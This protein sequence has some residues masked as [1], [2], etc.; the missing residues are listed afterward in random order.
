MIM[1]KEYE[2]LDTT[3][4]YPIQYFIGIFILI[5]LFIDE[6]IDTNDILDGWTIMAVFGKFDG[7]SLYIP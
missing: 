1:K 4:K 7:I 3:D 2:V 6:Y 5:N